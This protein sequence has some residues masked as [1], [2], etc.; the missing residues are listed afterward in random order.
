[1]LFP[2][3]FILGFFASLLSQTHAHPQA[4]QVVPTTPFEGPSDVQFVTGDARFGGG[5]D[6]PK[7]NPVNGSVFDVRHP[8]YTLPV[9]YSFGQSSGTLMSW[10][11]TSRQALWSSSSPV[12]AYGL[13]ILPETTLSITSLRPSHSP[14]VPYIAKT[15]RRNNSQSPPRVMEVV[16]FCP[17]VS[18]GGTAL[19]I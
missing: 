8:H 9:S 11:T 4:V 18:R 2:R 16:E 10:P 14:M 13:A 6:S 1:M 17:G 3:I 19:Q 5:F 15:C 7:I 12:T